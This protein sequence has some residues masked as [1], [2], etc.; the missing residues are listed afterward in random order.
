MKPN[1]ILR[2]V[3]PDLEEIAMK[4]LQALQEVR[5]S[6]TPQN[7]ANYDWMMLELYDQTVR[8]YGGGKMGEYLGQKE[9]LNKE[10][11]VE[12]IGFEAENYWKNTMPNFVEVDHS[13]D[14][15]ESEI[16]FRGSGEI[17]YWMY[18][19]FS[20]GRVM[21]KYGFVNI[22]QCKANESSIKNFSDYKLEVINGKERKP[23]SL[24]MEGIKRI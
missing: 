4:Y 13:N 11:I 24:Y 10:F 14:T 18:D 2:L 1:G 21:D 3:V 17:H 19:S 15:I 23:D 20:L 16:A 7:N 8:T 5:K 12:R 22:K 9:I 6:N